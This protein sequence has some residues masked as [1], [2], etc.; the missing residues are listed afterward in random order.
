MG[1]RSPLIK[2]NNQRAPLHLL[3]KKRSH[4]TKYQQ[5]A[6]AYSSRPTQS[7]RP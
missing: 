3:T 2:I 7:D 5:T 6:I 1:K 4:L